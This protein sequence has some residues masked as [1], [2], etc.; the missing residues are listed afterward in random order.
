[1]KVMIVDDEP[2][3]V[4]SLALVCSEIPDI[5]EINCLLMSMT[6]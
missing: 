2:I 1:M 3:A 4:E 5:D 6:H